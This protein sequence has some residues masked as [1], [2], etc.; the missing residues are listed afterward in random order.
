L[1]SIGARAEKFYSI[2]SLY[3]ISL[4]E[5][6]SISNDDHGFIWASSRAGILRLTEDACR[7]YD[8]PYINTNL[9]YVKIV[10]QNSKLVAYTNNG[11]IFT[12]DPVT[13]KFVLVFEA[14]KIP[15]LR[16][17]FINNILVDKQGGYWL[18]TNRGVYR[19]YDG[20]LSQINKSGKCMIESYDNDRMVIANDKEILFVNSKTFQLE[21]LYRNQGHESH[22][23]SSLYLDKTMNKLWIGT[24]SSGL[25]KFDF[26]SK[27]LINVLRSSLPSKPILNIEKNSESTLLVGMDGEGVW[28]LDNQGNKVLDVYKESVDDP[29]SLK[30]NGVYDIFCDENQRVWVCTY[31]GG[32]SFYDQATPLV[33]QIT[34]SVNNENSL[35]NNEVNSIIED[36]SGKLWFATNN[37]ISCWDPAV[38]KWR[39]FYNETNRPVQVFLTLCEDDQGRIWA[40]SYSSGVFVLDGQTGKEVMHLIHEK[41]GSPLV[42]DFIFRIFKDS[43]GDIWIGGPNGVLTCFLSNQ[44]KFVKYSN[45]SVCSFSDLSENE[46]LI[47]SSYGLLLQNKQTGKRRILYMGSYVR[48]L[49]V[50]N[51]DIWICTNG[52]GL[53]RYNYKLKTTEKFTVQSGLNSNFV[54][55]IISDGKYLWLGTENGLC[56]FDYQNNKFLTFS[57][58]YSLSKVSYN[59][60]AQFKLKNKQL[61]WGTN[62]GAVVFSPDMLE[63]IPLKGKIFYDDLTVSGISIR[64]NPEFELNTP[65]DQLE[66]LALKYYQNT[67]SVELFAI[68]TVAGS[69]FS[70]IL[71]GFDKNWSQPTD[72]RLLSYTNIPSGSY[73]LKIRLYDGSLSNIVAERSLKIKVIPPFWRRGWFWVMIF[74]IVAGMGFLY[75]QYYIKSLKQRHTEEKVRFF[76]NTAHDIRTSLTLIKSPI[77][78]LSREKNLSDAGR[79]YLNLAIEQARRLS[80]VVTQL[81]DF[82]KV[83]IGKEK[84]S[85][86]MVDIVRY[87]S[88]RVLMF[89]SLAKSKEVVLVFKSETE[90]FMTAI[91]ESK[92]EKIVDNLISNAVKYSYPRSKVN[93]DLTINNNKWTL[94]VKDT[95]IGIGKKAQRQLFN[96]FYRGE[97]AINSK[98]VGSGI[99]LL[100]VKNYVTMLGGTISCI[101]EEGQGALF[102]VVIPCRKTLSDQE[103]TSRFSVADSTIVPSKDLLLMATRTNPEGRSKEMKILVVEDNDDLRNFMIGVLSREFA[104]FSAE[105][106]IVAW[107][108]INK[109]MPDLVVSDVMM[110]KLNGF[111]LCQLLKSTYETSH[112]PIIL[113][114]ALSEKKEHSHGL[115]LGADDYLTKPFD[116][117]LLTQRIKSIIRNREIIQNKALKM[118]KG[119]NTEPLLANEL[120]D[121]FMK[122]LLEVARANMANAGFN[123]DD[124][125]SAMN[126]SSSL[127]Y[128]K[129]KALTNLSPSDFIKIMR[130]DHSLELLQSRQY[131]VTEVSEKCGF[132]SVGYFCT[133]FRKHF[134]KTPSEILE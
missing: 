107:D 16:F 104:V 41:E 83:D 108:L 76:T 130:L 38:N 68:K 115:G 11:Q 15:D 113:L 29:S 129:V 18:A 122:K 24:I 20:Q 49:L 65:V 120:N 26:H 121:K 96:E 4:R 102:Q 117:A 79:N 9:V 101:S 13:D 114:T 40:G 46:V 43:S 89:E 7:I 39:S 53:L 17:L 57:S 123:K 85:L 91:D 22:A 55:S 8:L 14:D 61:A 109:Q 23:V 88:G 134:G 30:G 48:N 125:A 58:I 99:G 2:N 124:F 126:V 42:N 112:I 94:R 98:I 118:I 82:Q 63:D 92:I 25:Y 34:H 36:H 12:Y 64:E 5:V 33:S 66:N 54:N 70:W 131:A 37:G 95:G 72:N 84:V 77:E 86:S 35:V 32:V 47:G 10:C 44:N 90:S 87:I 133:V 45:E 56:R 75:L 19:L 50:L 73:N 132:T 67:I 31:S 27:T 80:M 119:D 6:Y 74:I 71:E 103:D 52:D 59:P 1:N 60:G 111:E 128:K 69:K 110:P 62:N 97:N 21:S 100:L 81:M 93:V 28:K 116:M 105:N 127:L 106:G 51:D 3:G 78:E